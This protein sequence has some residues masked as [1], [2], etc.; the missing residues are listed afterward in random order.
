[1]TKSNEKKRAGSGYS[2]KRSNKK[3]AQDNLRS[4]DERNHSSRRQESNQNTAETNRTEIPLDSDSESAT[5]LS[6]DMAAEVSE[7]KALLKKT[8]GRQKI[9][10]K[11]IQDKNKRFTTFSKRKGGIMKKAFELCT[12]TGTEIMV[13]VASETG[14]V[15]TF[16]TPRLQP[17]VTTEA[18]KNL[19][20][21]C[22]QSECVLDP[23]MAQRMNQDGFQEPDINFELGERN[24]QFTAG[25]ASNI[26]QDSGQRNHSNANQEFCRTLY[27]RE[28]RPNIL[29]S[30]S[31]NIVNRGPSGSGTQQGSSK[32]WEEQQLSYRHVRQDPAEGRTCSQSGT[33]AS[34][35]P[36]VTTISTGNRSTTARD[37]RY[38]QTHLIPRENE[39]AGYWVANNPPHA[40]TENENSNEKNAS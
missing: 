12:L 10:I 26:Y 3:P 29:T 14:H 39:E 21:T 8:R 1:M 7:D 16:A 19:I 37:L 27:P 33:S 13:L 9:D 17:I 32:E 23:S 35:M 4:T 28:F 38:N 31:Y 22:L 36:T 11:F 34:Q 15:Y 40:A 24:L 5:P 20:Q 30:N 25:L 2:D 6:V 18:G